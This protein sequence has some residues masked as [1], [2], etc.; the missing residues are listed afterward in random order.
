MRNVVTT[1]IAFIVCVGNATNQFVIS[2][3]RHMFLKQV[4]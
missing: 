3:K 2:D 1:N 4:I